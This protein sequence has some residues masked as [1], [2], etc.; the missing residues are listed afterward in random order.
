MNSHTGEAAPSP[1]LRH[2]LTLFAESPQAA[3][4]EQVRQQFDPVQFHLI[5]AHITLC[6]EQELYPLEDVLP[7]LRQ[8]Q[9]PALTLSLGVPE[10]FSEGRGVWLPVW[11]VSPAYHALR[12]AILGEKSDLPMPYAHLTLLH[13]R[14]TTCTEEAWA[15]IRSLPLPTT[16][17][18]QEVSLIRQRAGDPWEVLDVFPLKSGH[19]KA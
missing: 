12:A 10:H 8:L 2:Q 6:R 3:L 7:R 4:L 5:G 9:F 11:P 17:T 16:L 15:Y 18:F 13:P 19:G 14:N 1:A